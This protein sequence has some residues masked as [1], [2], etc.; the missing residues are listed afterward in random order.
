[1]LTETLCQHPSPDRSALPS[2]VGAAAL[3]SA[4]FSADRMK[5]QLVIL[6]AAPL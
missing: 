4:Q 2:A 6:A 3:H 1:M 5:E